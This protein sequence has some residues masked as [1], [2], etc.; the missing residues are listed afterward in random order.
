MLTVHQH[1]SYDTSA[2]MLSCCDSG[3]WVLQAAACCLI[4]W[5]SVFHSLSCHSG[6]PCFQSVTKVQPFFL[7]ACAFQK[8]TL[9]LCMLMFG[10][11]LTQSS[12]DLPLLTSYHFWI[13]KGIFTMAMFSP[14]DIYHKYGWSQD[15][16]L[17]CC[18]SFIADSLPNVYSPM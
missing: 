17:P 5:W 15:G 13:L 2:V 6:L 9:H 8:Q 3:F 1:I 11:I 7:R 14:Q 4:I 12:E 16:L 10:M 18:F